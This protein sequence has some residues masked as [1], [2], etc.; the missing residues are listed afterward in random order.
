MILDKLERLCAN[1]K[2]RNGFVPYLYWQ[3]ETYSFG[4]IFR[5]VFNISKLR[6]LPF[7]C[8]HGVFL[9]D[10]MEPEDLEYD[11]K[12]Y[13]AFRKVS[14]QAL[15]RAQ[16]RGTSVI[17][18]PHPWTLYKRKHNITREQGAVGST[19]FAPHSFSAKNSEF[20]F[21]EIIDELNLLPKEFR[22]IRICLSMKDI[23]MGS[24]HLLEKYGFEITTAGH[25]NDRRFVDRFYQ[26]LSHSRFGLSNIFGSEVALGTDLGVP[27]SLIGPEPDSHR[28]LDLTLGYESL[29][30]LEKRIH[31]YKL[32][33]SQF[34][35]LSIEVQSSQYE[36]I[37]KALGQEYYE[38][39]RQVKK[40]L[41]ILDQ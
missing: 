39:L 3:S 9:H 34:T 6:Q 11:V 10:D 24:H 38:N 2:W 32:A 15:T 28:R 41:N 29:S 23:K 37:S 16:G 26:I 27:F 19:F 17:S 21:D 14:E 4:K 8:D 22:P 36:F 35:G 30:L 18:I 20:Y 31:M 7:S 12:L 13:L 1:R 5:E 40:F 25:V 33:R